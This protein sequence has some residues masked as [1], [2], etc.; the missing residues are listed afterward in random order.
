[1]LFSFRLIVTLCIL[2]NGYSIF[3]TFI[4]AKSSM[5]PHNSKH[6]EKTILQNNT[7]FLQTAK[8]IKVLNSSALKNIGWIEIFDDAFTKIYK[9]DAVKQNYEYLIVGGVKGV[10]MTSFVRANADYTCRDQWDSMMHSAK[11][12]FGDNPFV[13]LT[14]DSTDIQYYRSK[15]PWPMQDRDYVLLREYVQNKT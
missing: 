9:R 8:T 5:S 2:S 4:T 7:S 14:K 6:F 11:F 15:R 10:S 13:N 3:P 1:M 12:I